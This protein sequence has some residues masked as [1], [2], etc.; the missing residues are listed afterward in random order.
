MCG[1]ALRLLLCALLSS[2]VLSVAT[3]SA[4]DEPRL[5]L[6]V[7]ESADGH[8]LGVGV[9]GLLVDPAL[10]DAL[11]SGLPLRFRFRAELWRKGFFDR[12][13]D[14]QESFFVL[15]QDPLDA[16]YLLDTGRGETRYRRLHEVEQAVGRTLRPT[17]S[18]DREGRY[19]YLATLEIE[20]LS[21]SD[22]EE[23]RRWLS[24]DV[25]PAVEGDSN[26]GRALERGLRRAFVRL[27]GIPTRRYQARTSIFRLP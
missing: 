8:R 21:L 4:Q 14:A 25:Q 19:Y 13:E 12:L 23:L 27:I 5:V 3:A 20:T 22:L 18:P 9:D 16:R 15:V 24:G 7:V 10:H 26:V 1:L 6:N 17:L 2:G 11:R